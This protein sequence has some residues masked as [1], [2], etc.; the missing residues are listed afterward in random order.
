MVPGAAFTQSTE[1]WIKGCP[2][3]LAEEQFYSLV[4]TSVVASLEEPYLTG[5][6]REAR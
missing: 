5:I 3:F 6:L 1:T 4:L 2:H